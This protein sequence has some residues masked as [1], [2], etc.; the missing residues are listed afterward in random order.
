MGIVTGTLKDGVTIDGYKQVVVCI[1]PEAELS[2]LG[3]G[4]LA[5]ILKIMTNTKNVVFLDFKPVLDIAAP[6][7]LNPRW[8]LPDLTRLED[9]EA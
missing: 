9:Q 1:S 3:W 4:Y 2:F 8:N 6:R 5:P 7:S